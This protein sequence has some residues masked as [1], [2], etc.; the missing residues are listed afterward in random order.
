MS[1]ASA[2]WIIAVCGVGLW[3]AG[4]ATLLY[5]LWMALRD[6]PRLSVL[7]AVRRVILGTSAMALGGVAFYYLRTMR[8]EAASSGDL[9]HVE[10][11]G[12]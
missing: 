11:D 7:L 12:K 5:L 3:L 1:L 6:D 8:N 2:R 10:R 9:S 4:A